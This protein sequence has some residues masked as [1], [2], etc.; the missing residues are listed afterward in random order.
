[1]SQATC[2]RSQPDVWPHLARSGIPIKPP[3]EVQSGGSLIPTS[4]FFPPAVL[5]VFPPAPPQGHSGTP[6][7]FWIQGAASRSTNS[8]PP[9]TP[10]STKAA[11]SPAPHHWEFILS[12][13]YIWNASILRIP[14][15]PWEQLSLTHPA[16]DLTPRRVRNVEKQGCSESTPSLLL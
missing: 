12:S 9:Q 5:S 6:S 14:T 8:N 15:P 1:M 3:G 7:P 11:V 4:G 16:L 2:S 13:G 10:P